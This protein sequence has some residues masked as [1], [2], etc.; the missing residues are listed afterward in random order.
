MTLSDIPSVFFSD[1]MSTV[2]S[3]FGLNIGSAKREA[4]TAAIDI[5]NAFFLFSNLQGVDF[6]DVSGK[7]IT[8]PDPVRCS[9]DL[10]YFTFRF[11]VSA[12]T[13]DIRAPASSLFLEFSL[14]LPQSLST[15]A[16]SSTVL[17]NPPPVPVL[18]TNRSKPIANLSFKL[19]NIS[20]DILSTMDEDQMWTLLI[21]ARDTLSFVAPA[22][23]IFVQYSNLFTPPLLLSSLAP[24]SS[25]LFTSPLSVSSPALT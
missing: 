15:S 23:Y 18:V 17:I 25:T 1:L 6:S 21:D 13:V 2:A 9:A 20:N 7:P 12:A 3:Y 11:V 24:T 22:P 8:I 14:R 16:S 10:T 5:R 4:E 19:G